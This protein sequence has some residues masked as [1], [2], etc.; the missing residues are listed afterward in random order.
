MW[1]LCGAAAAAVGAWGWWRA[2]ARASRQRRL[3]LL[4]WRAG[5]DFAPL[6]PFPDTTWVPHP[7][8]SHA[9]MGSENVVWDR[10]ADDGLRV[11]DLWYEDVTDEGGR[12][13]RGWMTCA[14][15]PLPFSSP[16]L[17]VVPRGLDDVAVL[18]NEVRFELEA[19]DRRFRVECEDRRFAFAFLDQRMMQALLG[20]PEG[21]A[22]DATEDILVLHASLL[23]P[24]RALLLY[25]AAA[26]VRRRLPRVVSD[27]YPRRAVRGPHEAR[28]LQGR[29]SAESI[30]NRNGVR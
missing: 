6:D 26:A 7:L 14:V 10:E 12:P 22:L 29:W 21:V 24:E 9:R 25:E 16:R 20:L 5:L 23:P 4:C 1:W 2:H 30:G 13:P 27:L 11:F 17:T 19:F 8:F 18:G 3:M 28:W 15:V